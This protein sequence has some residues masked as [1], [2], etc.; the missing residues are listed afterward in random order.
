[1]ICIMNYLRSNWF[2]RKRRTLKNKFTS[3]DTNHDEPEATELKEVK[4]IKKSLVMTDIGKIPG[5][6]EVPEIKSIKKSN[7]MIIDEALKEFKG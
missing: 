7:S 4:E 3:S 5:E 6:A 1:M 2:N